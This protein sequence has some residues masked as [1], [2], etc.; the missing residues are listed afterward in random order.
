MSLAMLAI[1]GQDTVTVVINNDIITRINQLAQR[2]MVLAQNGWLDPYKMCSIF[3]YNN[4]QR[5][6]TGLIFLVASEFR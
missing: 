6:A 3:Q 2:Q 1:G 5:S 4:P